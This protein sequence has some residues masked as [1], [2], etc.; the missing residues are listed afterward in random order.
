MIK[1]FKKIEP[2]V[3]FFKKIDNNEIVGL[4]FGAFF[5]IFVIGYWYYVCFM[6]GAESWSEAII[7]FHRKIRFPSIGILVKPIILKIVITLFMLAV[8]GGFYAI[9]LS[10]LHRA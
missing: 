1:F 8:L 9:I 4:V 7:K 5:F 6:S 10:I 2:I 3:T